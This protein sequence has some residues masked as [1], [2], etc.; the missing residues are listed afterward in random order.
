MALTFIGEGNGVVGTP[1]HLTVYDGATENPIDP[2]TVSWSLP[3]NTI[4]EIDPTSTPP[5]FNISSTRVYSQGDA[6][7][8]A[9]QQSGM[10]RLTFAAAPLKF[11]S[12]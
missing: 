7:A 2:S 8:T 11:T 12:P 4:A 3:A 9:G 5:G 1:L 6:I 10:I